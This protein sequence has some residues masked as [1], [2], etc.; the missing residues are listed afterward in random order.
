METGASLPAAIAAGGNLVLDGGLATLL[1]RHGHDLTSQLWS[2]RLLHDDPD[3]IGRA[4]R[5]F[6]D[7]GAEVATTASYQASFDGF[8]HAGIDRDGAVALM[9]ASGEV[10]DRARRD[11]RDRTGRPA[12]VAVSVGPYGAALADGSEYRGDYG[13]T[14]DELRRWHHDRLQVLCEIVA[15]G[16][17]D[18][19]AVETIPSAAEADA[20]LREIEGTGI[21]VW[22]SLTGVLVAPGGDA[23]DAERRIARTRADE[24]LDE[25]FRAASEVPEVIAVGVNCVDPR[26]VAG[27]LA[28]ADG[29][30]LPLVCYPNSGELWDCAARSWYGDATIDAAVLRTWSAGGA[31]LVGGCCRVGPELIEQLAAA[32]G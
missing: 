5:E 18:V 13:L 32:L 24:P 22:L 9:R 14:V 23:P 7:A 8:A 28:A 30:A 6:F 1:E 2:A 27:L 25:S 11:H 16:L 17:A 21:P 26:D 3:A 15:D 29:T 19:L 10:A 31:R 20:L 4:H 12:F